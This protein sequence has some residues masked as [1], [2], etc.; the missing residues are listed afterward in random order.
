MAVGFIHAALENK[1]KVPKDYAVIGYD[2]ILFS[3]IFYPKLS[4]IDTDVDQLS[5][6]AI[7]HLIR[8]IKND[9]NLDR[10]AR[11]TLIPVNLIKRDTH[12]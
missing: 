8:M 11:K 10:S 5:V 9:V 3:K 6:E 1:K 2:N 4:T 7:D 12:K